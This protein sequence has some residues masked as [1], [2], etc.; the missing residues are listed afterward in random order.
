MYTINMRLVEKYDV[1]KIAYL[2]SIWDKIKEKVYFKCKS[3][4]DIDKCSK[5]A[6]NFMEYV[7]VKNGE[8][9][10]DYNED[11]KYR[12]FGK[13]YSIQDIPAYI[14][15]FLLEDA[16]V[17][18]ID[19]KN[20]VCACLLSFC[21]RYN[22]TC[23]TIDYY[24][25]NRQNIIDTYYG[26]SKDKCKEFINICF[27]NDTDKT[28]TNNDFEVDML[29]DIKLL[30]TFIDEAE[31]DD[32]Y[33]EGIRHDARVSQDKKG[34]TNYK[35]ASI[36][37]LYHSLECV[38]LKEAIAYYHKNTTNNKT[39]RTLMF[40][41]MIADKPDQEFDIKEMSRS[42]SI[43]MENTDFVFVYKPIKNDNNV[44]PPMP[45]DFYFD[46]DKIKVKYYL[47]L[48]TKHKLDIYDRADNNIYAEI[49]YLLYKDDFVYLREE[50]R[51][52]L[53][54][55]YK[56]NW[57]LN[58]IELC[59]SYIM[60]QLK[61]IYDM[62]ISYFTACATLCEEEK[63]KEFD[64]KRS[65]LLQKQNTLNYVSNLNNVLEY[66]KVLLSRRLDCNY[67]KFDEKLPYVVCFNNRSFDVRN[68]KEV[69]IKKTDYISYSTGYDYVKPSKTQMDLMNTLWNDIFPNEEIL[70][71][72]RSILWTGLTAIRPENFFMAN[73]CGRNG[74]GLLNELMLKT[75][76]NKYSYSGHIETLTQPIRKGANPELAQLNKKRFV[77]FE[78]PNDTDQL[79]LGNI[80]RLTGEGQL[81][82]REGFSNVTQQE[83][84]ASIL[85]ELNKRLN[86]NGR[87]DES[88]IE[89][90]V[91]IHFESYFTNDEEEIISNP[92]AKPKNVKY[93]EKEFQDSMRCALF[94]YLVDYADK[95][96]YIAD[97]VKN[98]TRE[99]LLDNDDL[100][101]WF[102]DTYEPTDDK[103]VFLKIKDIMERYKTSDV[104]Y[105]LSKKEKRKSNEK[106]FKIQI[107]TNIELR[108][109]YHDRK[110]I[111]GKSYYSIILGWKEKE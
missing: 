51:N 56:G 33:F 75:L 11:E 98:R 42:I 39:I 111:D 28:Y 82:A 46:Y 107:E 29:E 15:D 76:G 2:Y 48:F 4:E 71:T 96:L 108:K 92:K 77:K 8:I 91:D 30:Q 87:I 103:N 74:K 88:I 90:F 26:G 31:D 109:Y 47:K 17:V 18:D 94:D 78:E 49:M 1:K 79:Q 43:Y 14:R 57:I 95:E 35:G 97:C 73:G 59:K 53:Y 12:M 21:K 55:Y 24:Y 69:T 22:I 100:L 38:A 13:P 23:P 65:K 20:S 37:K 93:K 32:K 27:F 81:N 19:I 99:Y 61:D 102:Q 89:R 104:Y 84:V 67:I 6:I 72:Y 83:I 60:K 3:K 10:V 110:K 106:N 85:C 62:I 63:R 54:I 58:N 66:F 52:E 70:K 64:L 7:V 40:D 86:V 105:N 80:K 34:K 101:T 9:E 25:N 5:D 44:I 16:N 45:K 68:G 36:C 50:K 41:G